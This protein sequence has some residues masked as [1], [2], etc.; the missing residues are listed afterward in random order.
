MVPNQYKI[1]GWGTFPLQLPEHFFLKE[2]T[3]IGPLLLTPS[4]YLV[5]G[6]CGSGFL[7]E[8]QRSEGTGMKQD[9]SQK[10]YHNC[11]TLV[12]VESPVTQGLVTSGS[13]NP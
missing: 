5:S 9:Q 10:A 8:Q 2:D 3:N 7:S 13:V 4:P 6:D 12:K 11:G 1:T